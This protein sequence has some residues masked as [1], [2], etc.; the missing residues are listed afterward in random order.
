[1]SDDAHKP[2]AYY[3]SYYS[4]FGNAAYAE[5]RTAEFGEDLGQNN[6]QTPAELE[7][8]ASQLSS[9]RVSACSTSPAARAAC[10]CISHA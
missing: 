5:I 8:F 9:Q 7:R 3:G 6:W 10:R 4:N 1:M 2:A